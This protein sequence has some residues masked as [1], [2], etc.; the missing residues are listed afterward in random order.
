M[1]NRIG[2]QV[3]VLALVFLMWN[4]LRLKQET[5]IRQ[6]QQRLGGIPVLIV[7]DDEDELSAVANTVRRL[8]MVK[9]LR[10]ELPVEVKNR[11]LDRL[12][13][14]AGQPLSSG[15]RELLS[16]TMMPGLVNIT[17]HPALFDAA[18]RD[19]LWSS[20][21]AIRQDLVIRY[22]DEF[23]SQR[24]EEIHHL[25]RIRLLYEAFFAA[26][27]LLAAVGLRHVFEAKQDEYWRIVRRS[28][29]DVKRR[30][31]LYWKNSL[32]I[33]L[34]PSTISLIVLVGYPYYTLGEI[35]WP[36]QTLAMQ[37]GCLTLA[38]FTS[39]FSQQE[40]MS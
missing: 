7:S 10:L 20:L 15:S 3:L 27:A 39:W 9:E 32:V 11:L 36:W 17:V 34:L 18:G 30:R 6:V 29:G 28:G 2:L 13:E 24:W 37:A 8:S 5:L 16:G 12:E 40:K 23:W 38:I 21:H 1:H 33:L 19:S 25:R 35:T 26:L 31:R 4:T 22:N 14:S